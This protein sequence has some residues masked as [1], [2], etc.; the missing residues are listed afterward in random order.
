MLL[1][2]DTSTSLFH[3][4]VVDADLICFKNGRL[5][6]DGGDRNPSFGILLAVY[7]DVPGELCE[8]LGR[9]GTVFRPDE[10]FQRTEQATLDA[11]GGESGR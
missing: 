7:G 11:S 9:K 6:F 5:V 3:D 4:L 1:P 8:T 2:V 10:R